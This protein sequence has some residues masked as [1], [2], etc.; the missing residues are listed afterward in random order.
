MSKIIRSIG[1]DSNSK[2]MGMGLYVENP[3]VPISRDP[4]TPGNVNPRIYGMHES[5]KQYEYLADRSRSRAPACHLGFLLLSS[6]V[7]P[8]S[9]PSC[10]SPPS[11]PLPTLHSSALPPSAYVYTRS[12]SSTLP[13]LFL[14]FILPYTTFH[15]LSFSLPPSSFSSSLYSTPLPLPSLLSHS[16]TPITF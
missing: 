2:G 15:S 14:S 3:R 10:A 13:S 11:V 4:I 12:S 9:L 7:N 6:L 8:S 1:R 5:I 16:L